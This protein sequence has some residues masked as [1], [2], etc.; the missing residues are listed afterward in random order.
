MNLSRTAHPDKGGNPELFKI[1]RG[2]YDYL[3]N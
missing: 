1:I 2:S 3:V